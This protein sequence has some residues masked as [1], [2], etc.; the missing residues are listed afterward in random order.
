MITGMQRRRSSS[1]A[2][3][4]KTTSGPIPAGSPIVI[5]TRGRDRPRRGPEKDELLGNCL[6]SRDD[7]ADQAGAKQGR[8]SKGYLSL[9][10]LGVLLAF[11]SLIHV[12]DVSLKQ[13]EVGLRLPI[14]L[15]R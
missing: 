15:Q 10:F 2:T 14:D 7:G 12:F 9:L 11:V 4:F 8:E 3:A 1:S 13:K 6:I 5:A